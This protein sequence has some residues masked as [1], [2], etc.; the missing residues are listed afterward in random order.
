MTNHLEQRLYKAIVWVGEKP[1][2]RV[3][4]FALSL[5]EAGAIIKDKYGSEAVVSLWNEED[6]E[7]PRS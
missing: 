1:G 7:K 4:V 3:E 2:E 6:A 5:E